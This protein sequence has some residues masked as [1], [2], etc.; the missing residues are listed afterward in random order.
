MFKIVSAKEFIQNPGSISAMISPKPGRWISAYSL[1]LMQIQRLIQDQT[2][3]NDDC[4]AGSCWLYSM[5]S[6]VGT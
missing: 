6:A 4:I 1:H 3:L 2:L 5:K